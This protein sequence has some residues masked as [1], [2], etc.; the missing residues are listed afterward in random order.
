MAANVKNRSDFTETLVVHAALRLAA[1]Q[2]IFAKDA[3]LHKAAQRMMGEL[4]GDRTIYGRQLRMLE[5]MR[6]G[7]DIDTLRRKLRCSRRTIFRYLNHLEAAGVDIQL[8]GQ[9]Y[10]VSGKLLQALS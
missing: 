3:R 6:R 7:V 10:R 2:R 8:E 4:E 1:K 9:Q 5:L